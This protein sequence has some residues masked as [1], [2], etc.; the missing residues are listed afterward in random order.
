MLNRKK[1]KL[2]ARCFIAL[3]IAL[4]ILLMPLAVIAETE[5]AGETNE[6]AV[7]TGGHSSGG[8]GFDQSRS[9][10]EPSANESNG[11][12]VTNTHESSGSAENSEP[13]KQAGSEVEEG[14][15]ENESENDS[16]EPLP[17]STEVDEEN[18]NCSTESEE[19]KQS[20]DSDQSEPDEE[21][22][23]QPADEETIETDQGT[24]SESN[25][26]SSSGSE[27]GFYES[28]VGN[29][30]SVIL[31]D[32]GEVKVGEEIE[33][34]LTFTEIG[35]FNLTKIIINIPDEFEINSVDNPQTSGGQSWTAQIIGQV[36][37][38][39]ADL[40]EPLGWFSDDRLTFSEWVS[41]KFKATPRPTAEGDFTFET[42]AEWTHHKW[43]QVG[44]RRIVIGRINIDIPI[45]GW[46]RYDNPNSRC[47]ADPQ[48]QVKA[49]P[50]E[51][52]NDNG[53]PGNVVGGPTSGGGFD[54]PAFNFPFT[55]FLPGGQGDEGPVLTAL[56]IA[57]EAPLVNPGDYLV[58]PPDDP[59]TGMVP[60]V[61]AEFVN[62]ANREELDEAIAA[63]QV[64]YD[65][66][67]EYWE[68]MTDEEYAKHLL[69]L[70]AAWA[71]IQLREVVLAM[72]AGEEYDLEVV[73]EAYDLALEQFGTYGEYLNAE[74]EQAFTAV[75]DAIAE[76]LES[77]EEDSAA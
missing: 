46:R 65:Y 21:E 57:P 48:V 44:S 26:E 23:E 16:E 29:T 28:V 27:S 47:G 76:M 24:E 62:E 40:V 67:E 52:G 17:E 25:E 1:M 39:A 51:P 72:E 53:D 66:F 6:G 31:T 34:E 2:K 22:P 3:F 38:L 54:F 60:M 14:N 71:A 50:D 56:T 73:N 49:A 58:V 19:S 15:N 61:D 45:M 55:P 64:L 77:I 7:E 63:Y 9:L 68:E 75:I 12:K 5:Q 30:Y 18:E 74:Q 42:E 11:P 37:E 8:G 41:V 70:S 43:E 32:P 35:L 59:E 69:D 33:F 13:D 10:S 20:E 36:I 4:Q